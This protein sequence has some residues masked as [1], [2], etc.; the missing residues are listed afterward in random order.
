MSI[1]VY[2]NAVSEFVLLDAVKTHLRSGIKEEL[3]KVAEEV[4]NRVVDELEEQLQLTAQA[5]FRADRWAQELIV[6]VRD[7]R[8]NNKQE[9]KG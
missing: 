5:H 1:E 8:E 7:K 2:R 3:M 6:E 4:V 9:S